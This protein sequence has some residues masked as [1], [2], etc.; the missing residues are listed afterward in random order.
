VG[1]YLFGLRHTTGNGKLPIALAS[2][3]FLLE[4]SMVSVALPQTK[5]DKIDWDN[6]LVIFK[7][8]MSFGFV[9]YLA[10]DLGVSP[11][12]IQ[13][14]DIGYWPGGQC[15]V[16]FERDE[17]GHL[18]GAMRRYLDGRKFCIEGSHRGFSYECLGTLTGKTFTRE[19]HFMKVQDANCDCPICGKRTGCMI[20][21]GPDEDPAN[22]NAA[23]CYRISEGAE[24]EIPGAGWLHRLQAPIETSTNSGG[25]SGS[26]A[27]TE[28]RNLE[29][30]PPG[31]GQ[32]LPPSPYPVVLTEGA[33]DRLYA[34]TIGFVAVGLPSANGCK[35]NPRK[36]VAGRAVI[37]VGDANEVGR[38]SAEGWVQALRPVCPSVVLVYPPEGFVDLRKW[39]PT[40]TAFDAHVAAAGV[41]ANNS[42]VLPTTSPRQL[43]L[44]WLDTTH[45]K[46]GRRLLHHVC[47]S[48]FEHNGTCYDRLEPEQLQERLADFFDGREAWSVQAN[49]GKTIKKLEANE[50]LVREL[51]FA[52]RSRCHVPVSPGEHEPFK[53]AT[54]KSMDLTRAVIFQNGIYHVLDDT[55]EPLT[56][57]VFLTSTLPYAY[58]PGHTCPESLGL[59]HEAFQGDDESI[60]LLQEYAGYCLTADNSFESLLFLI[61]LPGSGK[62]TIVTMLEAM[63]GPARCGTFELADLTN[64]FSRARLLGRY[65]VTFSEDV[66]GRK[67]SG[68]ILAA[69]KR[70]TGNDSVNIEQKFKEGFDAKLFCRAIYSGNELPIFEDAS[71]SLSRRLNILK[72]GH[73]PDRPDHTLKRRLVHEA[74]GLAVWAMQGLRR[75]LENQKFT[76]P[77]SSE[78]FLRDAEKLSNPLGSSFEECLSFTPDGFAKKDDLFNLHV[79]VCTV[80]KMVPQARNIFF[81]RFRARYGAKLSDIDKRGPV[82][83]AT[84]KRPW[85]IEGVSLLPE[86]YDYLRQI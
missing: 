32:V 52:L 50:K 85:G 1:L 54:G 40:R 69:L 33:S 64:R 13:H 23:L 75:L 78:E 65:L 67:D 11:D 48:W 10:Q 29:T 2:G 38:R 63:L 36:L 56:P 22:A 53:V 30:V 81:S 71:R 7:G 25:S 12:S 74:P 14:S 26:G 34:E 55:L 73:V 9:D 5:S 27:F 84:Q 72:F 4:K 49:G 62:G 77:R 35:A 46:G 61:G 19:N 37:V 28:G 83:P 82:D 20:G 42:G 21:V 18:T 31:G 15:F 43:A 86:A 60:N 68:K 51:L 24:K 39:H 41:Q 66:V 47:G 8:N 76:R 6:L 45:A 44:S 17:Y 57:D 58:R 16:F 70:L 79:A 59:I 3:T 80:E